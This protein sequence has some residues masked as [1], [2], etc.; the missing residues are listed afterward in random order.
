[1]EQVDLLLV[2][3]PFIQIN[4]PYPATPNLKGF[5]EAHGFRVAQ[6]DLSIACITSIFSKSGLQQL[7]NGVAGSKLSPNAQRILKQKDDYLR[8]V[9]AAISFLQGKDLTFAHSIVN[10]ALPRASRFNIQQIGRASCRER[11]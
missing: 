8:H 11:V 2:T 3:P 4:T 6:L 7:F 1:M 5:L 10:G 9:D